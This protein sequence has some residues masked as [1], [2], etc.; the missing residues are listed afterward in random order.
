MIEIL[1]KSLFNSFLLAFQAW[2]FVEYKNGC[3]PLSAYL[4]ICVVYNIS[5]FTM[6]LVENFDPTVKTP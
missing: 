1:T 2:V 6:N 3:F 4:F 5:L